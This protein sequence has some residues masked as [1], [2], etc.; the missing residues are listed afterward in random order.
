MLA[1]VGC[2]IGGAIIGTTFH[3][4]LS[5]LKS[6]CWPTKSLPSTKWEKRTAIAKKIA[7]AVTIGL[8]SMLF[9]Q[10]M[11]WGEGSLQCV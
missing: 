2:G 3:K 6:I 5:L 11:F 8:L 9:P 10:T 7:V 1:S 4:T